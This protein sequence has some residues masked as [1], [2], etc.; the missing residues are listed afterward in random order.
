MK[1]TIIVGA[2]VGAALA[3]LVVYPSAHKKSAV[4]VDPSEEKRGECCITDVTLFEENAEGT[5]PFSEEEWAAFRKDLDNLSIAGGETTE[6]EWAAI[7]KRH[8]SIG[9]QQGWVAFRKGVD[10]FIE[11]LEISNKQMEMLREASTTR[12]QGDAAYRPPTNNPLP[13]N[14]KP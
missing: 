4:A 8:T 10:D 9:S 3:I 5:G 13:Y 7:R 1:N 12:P 11:A 6:E 14:N 2:V